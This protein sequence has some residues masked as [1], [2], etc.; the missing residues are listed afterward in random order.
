MRRHPKSPIVTRA[1]I[2]GVDERLRDVTSVFNPGGIYHDGEAILILR[3]Q[4]RARQTLLVKAI[5]RDGISFLTDVKPITI[6]GMETFPHKIY[7]IYDPRVVKL[8][9][10]FLITCA[11]DTNKGCRVGIFQSRDLD[12]MEYIGMLED[13]DQR[14]GVLFPELIGGRYLMLSRPNERVGPDGVRSGDRIVCYSSQD[15]LSWKEEAEVLKGEPHYWDELI[16]SG[17]PPI[18]TP[19]GWLLI[20]HGVATHFG[21]G[22]IYQAGIC[23]LD[24]SEPWKPVVRGP[25]N[26]LEP[27]ELYETVGQV[28]NVVFPTAAFAMSDKPIDLDT[29]LH[30]YYGAADTCVGLAVSTPQDMLLYSG[31]SLAFT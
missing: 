10:R 20:Y 27:R 15:L 7:H 24:P 28:P 25:Y 4:N 26:V 14:N 22:G 19:I 21:G 29:R 5:S 11:I 8:D 31:I 30:I 13:S 12:S 6:K 18:K 17:P 1:D 23:L 16:G 2:L 3:V 9:E